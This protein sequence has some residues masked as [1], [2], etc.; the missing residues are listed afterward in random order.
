MFER[1]TEA[2]RVALFI[3]RERAGWFGSASLGADYVFLGVC[4]QDALVAL[5]PGLAAS[6]REAKADVESAL[7]R[8]MP[9]PTSAEMAF[10]PEARDALVAAA[11]EADALGHAYVGVEHLLLGLVRD[12]RSAAAAALARRGVG[13]DGL[14]KAIVAAIAARAVAPTEPTE[15]R[16]SPPSG[17]HARFLIIDA[18]VEELGQRIAADDPVRP[19]VEMLRNEIVLLKRELGR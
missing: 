14:R 11:G 19:A 16:P 1:F 7:P 10:T 12:G 3:A 5:L 17:V 18:L 2:A 6:L 8:A 15:Q 4:E 13:V 9:E